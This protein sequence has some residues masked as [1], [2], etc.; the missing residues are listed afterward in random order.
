MK[1]LLKAIKGPSRIIY[2]VGATIYALLFAVIAIGNGATGGQFMPVFAGLIIMAAGIIAIGSVPLLMLL[3]KE[4]AAKIIFVV[5]AGYWLV[6]QAQAR[7][8][9]AGGIVDGVDGT[10][11]TGYV[12]GFISGIMLLIIGILVIVYT[13]FSKKR[14]LMGVAF[15]IMLSFVLV[16]MIT[17]III[18][19]AQAK[20]KANWAAIMDT[21]AEGFIVPTVVVFGYIY[22]FANPNEIKGED[23]EENKDDSVEEEVPVEEPAS[24]P[25]E[26]VKEAPVEPAPKAPDPVDDGGFEQLK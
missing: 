2:M 12:F 25:Q 24:V 4:D 26:E 7:I 21:V 1:E 6:S 5:L 17:G 23:K 8:G 3:K 9:M 22:F 11:V 14:G 18:L 10:A 20:A 16:A 15:W 13:I 19:I